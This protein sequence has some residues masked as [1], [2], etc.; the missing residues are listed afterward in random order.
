MIVNS[1]PLYQLNYGPKNRFSQYAESE[2]GMIGNRS[3]LL[4]FLLGFPFCQYVREEIHDGK[5][6]EN[7]RD[8]RRKQES[9]GY[10][11]LTMGTEFPSE[12]AGSCPF[13]FSIHLS[14]T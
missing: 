11:I 14:F 12:V 8:C 3:P 6:H 2:S 9:H 5:Y 4:S 10:L 13:H 7:Y 1:D